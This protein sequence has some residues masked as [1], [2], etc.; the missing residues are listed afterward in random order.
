MIRNKEGQRGKL[1]STVERN[2]H[3]PKVSVRQREKCFKC[4]KEGHYVSVCKSKSKD[5]RVN[6]LHV[7]STTASECVDCVLNEYEPVYFNAPI[8]HLNTV[9]VESLNHPKSE[10]HIRPLWFS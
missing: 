10:P 9:T 8:H 2:R 1:V 4:G 7:Q 5:A 3:I 6:E